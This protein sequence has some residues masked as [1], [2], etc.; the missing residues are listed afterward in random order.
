VLAN[1][2]GSRQL[3]ICSIKPTGGESKESFIASCLEIAGLYPCLLDVSL[4]D[5]SK[6]YSSKG[7]GSARATLLSAQKYKYYSHIIIIII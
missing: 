4:S 5:G 2:V 7:G 3:P 1:T 6:G